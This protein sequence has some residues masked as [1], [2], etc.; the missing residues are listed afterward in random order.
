MNTSKKIYYSFNEILFSVEE[1]MLMNELFIPNDVL[2]LSSENINN[3]MEIDKININNYLYSN[4]N[5]KEELEKIK[6]IQASLNY[7]YYHN[8]NLLK[9]VHEIILQEM[10]TLKIY[11]KK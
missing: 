11:Q 9:S 7:N 5:I 1:Y 2:K 3:L 8:Y 6:I 10:E 4:L